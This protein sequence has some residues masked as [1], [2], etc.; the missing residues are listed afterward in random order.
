MK[1]TNFTPKQSAKTSQK[2]NKPVG[3]P[4]SRAIWTATEK[5]RELDAALQSGN[6][7]Q[8]L[9]KV[10]ELQTALDDLRDAYITMFKRLGR[11]V[12]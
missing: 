8:V 7:V 4:V 12:A 1:Q 3:S 9:R 2:P 11:E 10:A 6:F 5:S